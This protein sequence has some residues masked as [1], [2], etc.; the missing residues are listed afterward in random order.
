MSFSRGTMFGMSDMCVGSVIT[1][2]SP[3]KK[4]KAKMCHASRFPVRTTA[5]KAAVKTAW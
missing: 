1:H 5:A 2:P 4:M 3:M